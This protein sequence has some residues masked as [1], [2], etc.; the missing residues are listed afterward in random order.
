[1]AALLYQSVVHFSETMHS[2]CNVCL[3]QRSFVWYKN[4][5]TLQSLCTTHVALGCGNKQVTSRQLAPKWPCNHRR[6]FVISWQQ[7]FDLT[8]STIRLQAYDFSQP[9]LACLRPLEPCYRFIGVLDY[10]E[11]TKQLVDNVIDAAGSIVNLRMA[12]MRY[13]HTCCLASAAKQSPRP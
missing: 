4:S 5:P 6:C 10:G 12:V 1:M 9:F 8:S 11:Q 13:A 7:V 3:Q 2:G